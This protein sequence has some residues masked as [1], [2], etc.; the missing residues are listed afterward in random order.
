[1][2]CCRVHAQGKYSPAARILIG[3][4]V[5]TRHALPPCEPLAA[6]SIAAFQA[7]FTLARL[8]PMRN[9]SFRALPHDSVIVMP[10]FAAGDGGPK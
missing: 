1:M 6:A 3:P 2:K 5:L 7:P 9:G 8:E 4:K 10:P